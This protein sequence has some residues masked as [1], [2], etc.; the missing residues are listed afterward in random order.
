M[1]TSLAGSY[2]H[3]MVISMSMHG[4]FHVGICA[5]INSDIVYGKPLWTKFKL[6]M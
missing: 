3:I 5:L 2:V 1:G 4:F 6:F